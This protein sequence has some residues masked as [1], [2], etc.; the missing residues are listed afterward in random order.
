MCGDA[1]DVHEALGNNR[2]LLHRM[3]HYASAMAY[4]EGEW[5]WGV[6]RLH[7]L[8]IRLRKEM[9]SAMTW[10]PFLF[11]LEVSLRW[12]CIGFCFMDSNCGGCAARAVCAGQGDVR[13]EQD[14]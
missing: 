4:F 14:D 10:E 11:N 8:E 13:L 1:T 6:S 12:A 5:Y 9:E 2:Q 3:K 7:H